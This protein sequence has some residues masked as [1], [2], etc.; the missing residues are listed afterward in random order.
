M[1]P[2]TNCRNYQNKNAHFFLKHKRTPPLKIPIIPMMYPILAQMG[3]DKS[4][5]NIEL[6]C[7]TPEIANII[8]GIAKNQNHLGVLLSNFFI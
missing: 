8:N 1:S 4:S 6:I 7:R 3:S 2:E 5:S